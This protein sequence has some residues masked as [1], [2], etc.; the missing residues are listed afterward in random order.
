MTVCSGQNG[1]ENIG[2]V[3]NLGEKLVAAIRANDMQAYTACWISQAQMEAELRKV[4]PHVPEQQL[5]GMREYVAMR[6]KSVRESFFK[7]QKLIEESGIS[8]MS[9]TLVSARAANVTR[10]NSYEKASAF[11][12]VINSDKGKW[13]YRID[14]GIKLDDS[15]LFSDRPINLFFGDKIL[16]FD[17]FENETEGN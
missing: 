17:D 15:W 1:K 4:S 9:I 16:S 6:D 11:D 10:A 3:A 8:R 5:Q 12:I 7:I 13:T 2:T 14:D